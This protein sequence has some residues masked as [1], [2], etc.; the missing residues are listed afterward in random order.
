MESF[1]DSL[2]LPYLGMETGTS[3][4]PAGRGEALNLPYLGME[5]VLPVKLP[6]PPHP[7][8]FLI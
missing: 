8:I 3:G 4:G 2:N 5:T 6:A 7:S 1:S